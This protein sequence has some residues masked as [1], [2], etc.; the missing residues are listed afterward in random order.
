MT[1]R[2]H[3]MWLLSAAAALSLGASASA[4][5]T[6]YTA[7]ANWQGAVGSQYTTLDFVF[8]A[9]TILSTQYAGLG[10]IFPEEEEAA[11]PLGVAF[12]QD[13]WGVQGAPA[14]DADIHIAFTSPQQWIGAHYPGGLMYQLLSGGTVIYNSPTHLTPGANGFFGIVSD[15][16]FDE[17]RLIDPFGF[18]YVDNIYFGG[19]VPS[20]GAM[21]LLAA[22][23]FG[24]R[25]RRRS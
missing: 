11:L 3:A 17:V 4:A 21:P 15:V 20:P 9:P 14:G 2:E 10:A 13:G 12:P 5:F 6:T 22:A 23:L 19:P 18:V 8:P 25:R 16:P 1:M 7:F 24:A